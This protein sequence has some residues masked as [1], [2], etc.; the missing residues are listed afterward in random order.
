MSLQRNSPN[1]MVN[2]K[3]PNPH[4]LRRWYA[5]RPSTRLLFKRK[6]T[7]LKLPLK[8]SH[9]WRLELCTTNLEEADAQAAVGHDLR[10]RQ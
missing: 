4:S 10:Q 6:Q 5:S 9:K 8:K 7:P 3:R 1:Q 2:R